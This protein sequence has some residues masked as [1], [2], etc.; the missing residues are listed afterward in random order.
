MPNAKNVFLSALAVSV[1]GC[2]SRARTP[3]I[4]SITSTNSCVLSTNKELQSEYWME[5]QRLPYRPQTIKHEVQSLDVEGATGKR[6][7]RRLR[8]YPLGANRQTLIRSIAI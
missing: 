5:Q 1:I 8:H 4:R 6:Q 3:R 2:D 7:T